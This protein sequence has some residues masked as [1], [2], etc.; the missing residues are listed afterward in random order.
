[1][2]DKYGLYMQHFE[3][4]LVDI[5]KKTDKA[6]LEGTHCQLLKTETVILGALIYD[7]LEPAQKLS[8]KTQEVQVD[9]I[10]MADLT[11]QTRRRYKSL[12]NK[13]KTQSN[14]LT[15]FPMLKNNL[16]KVKSTNFLGDRSR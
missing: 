11:G 9:L 13:I 14:V 7:L 15:E 12:Q 10:N 5:V 2:L 1:M 4:I 8:L 6:T 16:S 3:N